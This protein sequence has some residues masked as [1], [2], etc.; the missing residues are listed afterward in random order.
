MRWEDKIGQKYA[1][2]DKLKRYIPVL[3]IVDEKKGRC[4]QYIAGQ[5]Q[6]GTVKETLT[7]DGTILAPFYCVGIVR[8]VSKFV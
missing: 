5:Q 1:C 3:D 2:P 8:C 4:V 6:Q 7:R